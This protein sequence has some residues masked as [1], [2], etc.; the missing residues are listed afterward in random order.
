M[1]KRRVTPPR[2]KPL[3]AAK[4][5]PPPRRPIDPNEMLTFALREPTPQYFKVIPAA[6]E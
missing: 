6:A 1:A 5:G 3:R 4:K 2:R